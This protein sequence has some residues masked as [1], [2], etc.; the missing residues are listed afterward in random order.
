MNTLPLVLSSSRVVLSFSILMLGMTGCASQQD[1]IHA[2][3]LHHSDKPVLHAV[4]SEEL[5][6]LMDR[7]DSLMY[8]RFMTQTEIDR[9]RQ[10]YGRLMAD[11]ASQLDQ[12]VD[13]IMAS[14]PKLQLNNEESQVFHTL[15]GKLREQIHLLQG[16]V[17]EQQYQD[18]SAT[19]DQMLNTCKGCHQLFR[20]KG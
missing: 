20:P 1:Q 10:H 17:E 19:V 18:M 16:Q 6:N 9:K 14:L 4:Q 15:A 5:R 8:E 11:S 12:T 3:L 7:L 13:G 2:Q